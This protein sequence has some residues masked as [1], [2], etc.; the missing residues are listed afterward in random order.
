VGACQRCGNFLCTVCRTRW[1]DR[2]LCCACVDRALEAKE[3]APQEVRVHFRQSLL[4]ILF[5]I[6]AWVVLLLGGVLAF[7][8]VAGRMNVVLLGLGSLVFFASPLFAAQGVGQAAAALRARGDHMIMA[9]CGL[10]LS[11][12]E[13]GVVI[14][15]FFF[16]ILNR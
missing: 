9:T 11:A 4:A 3:A 7:A 6:A 16:S 13:A 1:R 10:L 12:L 5:G 14:G 2:S 8:G 15:L